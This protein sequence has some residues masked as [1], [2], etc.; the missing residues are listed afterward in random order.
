MLR[1]DPD[2][3]RFTRVKDSELKSEKIRER[4]DLQ[5]AIVNSWG[6]FRNEIGFPSAFLI[7]Q[8]IRPHA[9]TNDA[10]DLLAFDPDDSSLLVI[11]LKRDR[12][13]LQLLQALSYAAMLSNWESEDLIEV[14]RQ[15]SSPDQ[16]ELIELLRATEINEDVKVILIAEGFDPEVIITADWLYESYGVQITAFALKLHSMG[17]HFFVY[18]EQRYPLKELHDVYEAR[19]AKGKKARKTETAAQLSWADVIPSLEYPFAEKVIK[20][21]SRIKAGEPNRRRF[22]SLR[23]N[24]EGLDWISLNLRKKYM[25]VYIGGDFDGVEEFLQSKF[26][27]PIDIGSWRDGYSFRVQTP[28]QFGDLVKWLRLEE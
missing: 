12:N 19:G 9:S 4:Y 21:C 13:K 5:S 25:N 14:V 24:Y 15:Q 1:F 22:G 26:S 27:E 17:E 3:R 28:A 2:E 23:T 18:L 16:D 7:G 11:E 8:E 20:L 6:V 10:L